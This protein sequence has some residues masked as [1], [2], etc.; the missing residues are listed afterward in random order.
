LEKNRKDRREFTTDPKKKKEPSGSFI[1]EV[2][3][4]LEGLQTKT[5]KTKPKY[6]G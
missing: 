1:P 3:R 2:Q 4:E 5:K 6:P